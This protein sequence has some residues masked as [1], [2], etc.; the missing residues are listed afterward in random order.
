MKIL[1][2][3]HTGSKNHGCEAIVKTI[4]HLFSKDDI[5][6]YSYDTLSDK[7]FGLERYL[8]L[9]QCLPRKGHYS[10]SE[11]IKIRLHLYQEGQ[12]SFCEMLKEN[13]L[14]WAFAIGGDNYCYEGQPEELAYLNRE[15]HKRGIKTALFG[16]SINE[17]IIAKKR[18][19]QDLNHYDMIL[20]R[21]S[22][23]FSNL[24]KYNIKNT[25]LFPDTA[26]ILPSK[27][28]NSIINEFNDEAEYIGINLSPL[29]SKGEKYEGVIYQN[30]VTLID[31]IIQ[32]S[33]FSIMLIPHVFVE[34]DN[35]LDVL[36]KL[37]NKYESTNR[38]VLIKEDES[39][40]LKWYIQQCR[41]VVCARTHVSIAAYSQEI[42]T[43]VVG[44]SV[45]S[46]GIAK[47]LFGTYENYVISA[48]CIDTDEYLINAFHWLQENE[49]NIRKELS[50]KRLIYQEQLK[51]IPELFSDKQ[52]QDKEI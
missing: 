42:P 32:H 50:L 13:D 14:D 44:Y 46:R 34:W 15:L 33:S 39:S 22:L 19:Q 48:E 41:F 5:I 31:D 11:R 9:K 45:K 40:I 49:G 23:T 18:I 4:C 12:E 26:F 47:D 21:E 1:L 2:Y 29:V 20:A 10:I 37:Y 35:D 27:E 7:Q 16:C 51:S 38:I 30:F 28:K 52:K 36:E 24:Q 17:E 43:L 8:K 3:Y 25:Y 6:L